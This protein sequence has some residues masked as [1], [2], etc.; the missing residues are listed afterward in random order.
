MNKV[1]VS[2]AQIQLA[3]NCVGR[4]DKYVRMLDIAIEFLGFAKAEALYNQLPD[5]FKCDHK[6][7]IETI[8]YDLKSLKRDA[9]EMA[10]IK[11]EKAKELTDIRVKQLEGNE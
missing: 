7:G 2:K 11:S 10:E 3:K 8:L 5:S 1:T 9:Q 4:L 6:R